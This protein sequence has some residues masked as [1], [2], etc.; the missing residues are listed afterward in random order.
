MAVTNAPICTKDDYTV[1]LTNQWFLQ[2]SEYNAHPAG[3]RILVNGQKA[4]AEIH[5][6]I[7]MAKKNISII[8]WGFQ[9]SMYFVRNGSDVVD[10]PGI[11]K[12]PAQ[13]GKLLEVKAKAG[14]KVR[15]LCFAFEA[16][17]PKNAILPGRAPA[18]I[19]G[20]DATVG[21]SNTPGRWDL[22]IDDRPKFEKDAQYEYDKYWYSHYDDNQ[23][24]ENEVKKGLRSAIGNRAASNIQFY[25]R[26]FD[27]VDRGRIG[28]IDHEDKDL[29]GKT[30]FALPGGP[31]HHQKTVLVDYEDPNTS[32]AFIMG[33]NMLDEY[34]DTDRHLYERV[35]PRNGRNGIVGPREDFST[36]LTGP[37]VGD[38]F[39][40]FARAWR[41]ETGEVLN[42]AD[43]AK[44][45]PRFVKGENPMDECVPAF[46]QAVRT[47]PQTWPMTHDIKK[48]YCEAVKHAN[49]YIF[50]E[51]QYFRWPPLAEKI[52]ATARAQK[53]QGRKTP[54][55]LFVITNS[56]DDGVGK[57]T[58]NTYRMMDA[59]G[60]R[61]TL[62]GI[63][64]AYE[65]DDKQARLKQAQQKLEIA[66]FNDNYSRYPG[67]T[68]ANNPLQV[69]SKAAIEKAKEGVRQAQAECKR[70]ENE[71]KAIQNGADANIQQVEQPG[72]KTHICTLVAPKS[73]PGKWLEIYIHAKLMIVNDAFTTIGSANINTRSMEVDSEMNVL[74]DRPEIAKPLRQKLWGMHTKGQSGGDDMYSEYKVWQKIIDANKVRSN[75]KTASGP[76]ASLRGF[77]RTSPERTNS[78]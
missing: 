21:E 54:I 9:P 18:N 31:S 24:I 26:G 2:K 63:T 48:A 22:R 72:L 37:I 7:A 66:K 28:K 14:V 5:R 11:G 13:I 71:I 6:A 15:V 43:F 77:L 73:P 75:P 46:A 50:I 23:S 62:P 16:P 34:W 17:N 25:N 49:S 59:L 35:H 64:K 42:P 70:L 3:V 41:R 67:S 74:L 78:D 61:D 10:Y 30:V 53:Q 58:V 60:R 45:P 19:T 57:G 55:Y 69:R 29:T 36:K 38:V 20:M 52:K 40:N 51:N 4:F 47:Q 76:L 56:T 39:Y 12:V 68:D 27:A 1:S 8:C 33:H 32:I 65:Q 44:Y